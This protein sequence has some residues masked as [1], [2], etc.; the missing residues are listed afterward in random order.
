MEKI[1]FLINDLQSFQWLLMPINSKMVAPYCLTRHWL[2]AIPA[3]VRLRKPEAPGGGV[4][5][6]GLPVS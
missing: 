2:T 6:C 5:V 4:A 1:Y 3:C